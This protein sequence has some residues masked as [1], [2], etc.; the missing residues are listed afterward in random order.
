MRSALLLLIGAVSFAGAGFAQAPPRV[1]WQWVDTGAI[2]TCGVT[3]GGALYCWGARDRDLFGAGSPASS[4]IP[5]RPPGTDT[6]TF[7]SVDVGHGACALT[8]TDAMYCWSGDTGR[9]LTGR[10]G[11]TPGSA[12]RAPRFV[13]VSMGGNTNCGLTADGTAYCWGGNHVGQVGNGTNDSVSGPTPVAG[14]LRFRAIAVGGFHV[15]AIV[16]DG[17][18]YCWGDNRLGQLGTGDMGGSYVPV[19][20][21]GDLTFTALALAARLS[22]GIGAD[23]TAYCWGEDLGTT[24]QPVAG[25][26]KFVAL[27]VGAGLVGA[28]ACGIAVSGATYCWGDNG[29]G[30]LGT[31]TRRRSRTPVPV[32]GGLTFRAISAGGDYTC[33]IA[34]DGALYCW[35]HNIGG[36]LGVARS[37]ACSQELFGE[38]LVMP[39]VLRPTRVVEPQ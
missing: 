7:R 39:C 23:S 29:L 19:R 15:C 35:G 9:E 2:I 16:T 31:G 8:T 28:H 32:A 18:A 26:P 22:C 11:D 14:N 13:Q 4:G 30:Q 33:G 12:V 37:G 21:A 25:A 1:T 38:A 24:P 3:T 34:T 27:A 5:L 20:V 17:A 6:L 10:S 36:H